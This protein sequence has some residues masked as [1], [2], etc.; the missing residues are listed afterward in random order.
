MT[1][2]VEPTI[3]ATAAQRA[4]TIAELADLQSE[5]ALYE[6]ARDTVRAKIAAIEA[7]D[8]GPIETALRD[9]RTRAEVAQ[10]TQDVL[11]Y[12]ELGPDEQRRLLVFQAAQNAALA[13]YRKAQAT[14]GAPKTVIEQ[15]Y[16]AVNALVQSLGRQI[17]ITLA[18]GVV[19][20]EECYRATMF[21]K[22]IA[23]RD[24]MDRLA[25]L[26][27]D[28]QLRLQHEAHVRAQFGF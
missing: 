17:G 4:A 3:D 26:P 28:E 22:F 24:E 9:L 20:S 21:P 10:T 1:T 19:L 18:N 15:T 12:R 13:A 6:R 5:V 11:A 8:L 25:T 14:T 7:S 27:R 23:L 2:T 16:N